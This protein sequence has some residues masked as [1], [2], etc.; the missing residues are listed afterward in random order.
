M[1]IRTYAHDRHILLHKSLQG[2]C[3]CRGLQ[4]QR[5]CDQMLELK[6]V[7]MFQKLAPSHSVLLLKSWKIVC[8]TGQT[9]LV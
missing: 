2:L 6:V 7:Q 9:T 4:L 8:L 5:Q 3:D 1:M